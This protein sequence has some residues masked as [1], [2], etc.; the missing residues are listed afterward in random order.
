MR[1]FPR[2]WS[3]IL[4]IALGLLPEREPAALPWRRRM[5]RRRLLRGLFGFEILGSVRSHPERARSAR[6]THPK[7]IGEDDVSSTLP[8]ARRAPGRRRAT[9]ASLP[10]R[11][12]SL[13]GSRGWRPEAPRSLRASPVGCLR[14]TRLAAGPNPRGNRGARG[15]KHATP[16]VL[17]VSGRFLGAVIQQPYWT[18]TRADGT[19]G[20]CET[21]TQSSC[22]RDCDHIGGGFGFDSGLA[23]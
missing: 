17:T 11:Q 8:L 4:F 13:L 16:L 15:L 12:Q 7:K 20:H 1:Y 10:S 14:K 19:G 6:A 21:S 2:F 22:R 18:R 23:A 3:V 5:H 9:P